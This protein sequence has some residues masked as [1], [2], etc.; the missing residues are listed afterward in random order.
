[1]RSVIPIPT[2]RT[3][4]LNLRIACFVLAWLGLLTALALWLVW[5]PSA[6][7]RLQP[8]ATC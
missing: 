5:S 2:Q 8:A 7:S 4:D 6:L 3:T 1:M